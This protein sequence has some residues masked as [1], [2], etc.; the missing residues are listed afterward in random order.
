MEHHLPHAFQE[1][2][3]TVQYER[4][5][6]TISATFE[7]AE[8]IGCDRLE[9]AFSYK[10]DREIAQRA[11]LAET[12]KRRGLFRDVTFQGA[13]TAGAAHRLQRV[14]A[15][16]FISVLRRGEVT[17]W[18]YENWDSVAVRASESEIEGLRSRL[19][20]WS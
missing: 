18:V 11:G 5:H 16:D 15:M 7:W 1:L 14:V 6:Q 10:L 8:P 2:D 3:E 4:M 13:F 19:P 17:V 9:A 12:V 20:A